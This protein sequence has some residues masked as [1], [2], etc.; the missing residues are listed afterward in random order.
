MNISSSKGWKIL[1]ESEEVLGFSLTESKI[2]GI[3]GGGTQLTEEGKSFYE[4][5][6]TFLE[7]L[8]EENDKLLKKFFKSVNL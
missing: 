5:Y 1:K 7:E 2:G 6:L 4:N 3:G 8:E